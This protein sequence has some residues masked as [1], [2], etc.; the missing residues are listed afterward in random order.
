MAK[1][2]DFTRQWYRVKWTPGLE[3][4]PIPSHAFKNDGTLLINI[5]TTPLGGTP[6]CDISWT[7]ANGNPCAIEVLP[8]HE[9]KGMLQADE[10]EV[11]FRSSNGS[12]KPV[13][14]AVALRIEN[15]QLMGKLGPPGAQDANTGTFIADANPPRPGEGERPR[16]PRAEALAA[17]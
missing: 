7:D 6:A 8:F 13:R 5:P 17:T 2:E 9:S 15:G 12:K 10:I 3:K 4:G 11:H 1:I 16:R 14:L